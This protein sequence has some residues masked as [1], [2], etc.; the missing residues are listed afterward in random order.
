M[1]RPIISAY[2]DM[3]VFMKDMIAYRKKNE[4]HFSV[5][6]LC[7][8]LRHVSPALISLMIQGKRRLNLDRADEL[9]KLI[10]LSFHEKQ[11]FKDWIARE[12]DPYQ[13][14]I[15]ATHTEQ[16]KIPERRKKASSHILMDWVNVYVKDA[17]ELKT[18]KENPKAI[19]AALAGVASQKRIDKSIEFLLKSGYLRRDLNGKI[20]VDT[21]L[22]VVDQK[23]PDQ[24]VKQFHKA[25]L[26]NAA[27]ALDLYPTNQSYAN[28]LV[29]HLDKHSYEELTHLIQEIAERLQLFAEQPRSGEGLYQ[30]IIN[31]S[32][33]G[34]NHE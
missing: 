2:S 10:G 18:I 19:Y 33:T 25:T 28:A 31:L 20:V 29:M 34:S 5:L 30:L 6:R 21:S 7:K 22:H 3:R 23:L 15:I 24:K 12:A 26:K 9:A 1:E 17:F 32:P 11:Y 27:Q 4:R 8:Q 14:K 13:Q 16:K